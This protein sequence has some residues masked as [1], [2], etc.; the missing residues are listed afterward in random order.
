MGTRSQNRN[1]QYPV[2]TLQA[3]QHLYEEC[4]VY[5]GHENSLG[6]KHL[7]QDRIGVIKGTKVNEGGLFGDLHLNPKHHLVESI[8]WDFLNNSKRVGL[9]QDA[10]GDL[11]GNKVVKINS[12]KSIDLV[13]EPASTSSLREEVEPDPTAELSAKVTELTSQ[14]AAQKG[15]V[16]ELSTKHGQLLQEVKDLQKPKPFSATPKLEPP[17]QSQGPFNSADWVRHLGKK[18]K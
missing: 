1:R 3:S 13:C 18:Y 9:S 17:A 11:Q 6:R 16:E 8:W 5:V 14:L 15:L 2:E 12:V 4:P 10:E 7:Y